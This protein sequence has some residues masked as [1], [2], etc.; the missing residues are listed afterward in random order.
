MKMCLECSERIL[1]REDKKFCG[2]G[3]RNSYN[4]KKN[5]DKTNLMRNINNKLRKNYRILSEL[6]PENKSK[7][8]QAK[9]VAENFDFKYFTSVSQTKKGAVYYFVYDQ[10]YREITKKK[11]VLLKKH[12]N[13]YQ[14]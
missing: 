6:N 10:G 11:Y 8:T 3:C 2:D 13:E 14:L 1:G 5:K 4:N 12:L 7:I 9:L